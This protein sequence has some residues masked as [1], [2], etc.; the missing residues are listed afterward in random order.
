MNKK[1]LQILSASFSQM[2]GG[3]TVAILKCIVFVRLLLLIRDR[4]NTAIESRQQS[5]YRGRVEIGGVYLPS[6]L[7][8]HHN[9]AFYGRY[10]EKGWACTPHPPNQAGL[11]LPS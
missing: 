9:F 11:I 4:K 5:T 2:S 7:D 10:S 3:A 8:V 6:Q 1:I